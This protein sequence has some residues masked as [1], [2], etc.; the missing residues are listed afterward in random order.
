LDKVGECGFIGDMRKLYVRELTE[1]EEQALQQGLWCKDV[2]TVRR[3]Q[4]LLSSAEGQPAGLIA[5]QLRCS[6]QCVREAIHAFHA[7]GLKSLQRKSTRPHSARFSFDEQAL[8]RL[9]DVVNTSPRSYG[10][11]HSLWSLERLAETCYAE[12]LTERLVNVGTMGEALERAGIDWK[13]ARKRM[14]STDAAYEVKK[15]AGTVD[16]LG[17]TRP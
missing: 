10:H 6:D 13:R 9:P 1:E 17:G 7:E 2:F 4:I 3:S 8:A 12:G 11:E 5:E 16:G 14:N 15:T